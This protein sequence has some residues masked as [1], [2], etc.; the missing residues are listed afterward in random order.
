MSYPQISNILLAGHSGFILDG[1]GYDNPTQFNFH[2]N[3]LCTELSMPWTLSQHITLSSS[4][5]APQC[6]GSSD[7]EK[8]VRPS[9]RTSRHAEQDDGDYEA[10]IQEE[11]LVAAHTKPNTRK[12]KSTTASS[13]RANPIPLGLFFP[14]KIQLPV[15]VV[16]STIMILSRPSTLLYGRIPTSLLLPPMLMILVF[17]PW[18]SKTCI[19]W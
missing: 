15:V 3:E 13:S 18:C 4:C 10:E 9:K 11:E 6:Q 12:K 7:S 1:R 19:R 5:A 14:W 16:P 2:Q 17:A 8:R